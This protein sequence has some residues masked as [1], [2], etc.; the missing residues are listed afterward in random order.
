MNN[1]QIWQ[2]KTILRTAVY[3]SC[4]FYTQQACLAQHISA[5]VQVVHS[6]PILHEH[7][8]VMNNNV[9]S[10]GS[11]SGKDHHHLNSAVNAN[12]H[13][14]HANSFS[15]EYNSAQVIRN[16]FGLNQGASGVINQVS[17]IE[18]G[19][20]VTNVPITG[21]GSG[22]HTNSAVG[23]SN[24]GHGHWQSSEAG[25]AVQ[26]NAVTSGQGSGYKHEGHALTLLSQAKIEMN[27]RNL[28]LNS[29]SDVVTWRGPEETIN[30][31]SAVKTLTSGM[32]VTPSEFQAGLEKMSTGVQSLMIGS[33]GAADGGTFV[34]TASMRP[35]WNVQL[36]SGVTMDVRGATGI[37]PLVMAGSNT[38]I[39]GTIDFLSGKGSSVADLLASNLV[40][41]GSGKIIDSGTLNL[42]LVSLN[43]AGTI[44]PG[45]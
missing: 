42:N 7:H 28:D 18:V 17:N 38:K 30:E 13:P 16:Y 34:V 23:A 14:H 15:V 2:H 25:V 21:A 12:N 19:H 39:D 36:P 31:G 32:L 33:N 11:G 27:G 45:R 1:R 4:A 29:T 6:G 26:A 37:N 10:G 44:R 24:Q 35:Y 40:V 5:P 9:Q 22:S 43:N 41:D 20:A 3:L 8:S